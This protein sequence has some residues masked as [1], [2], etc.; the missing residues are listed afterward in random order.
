MLKIKMLQLGPVMT[1]AY[2]VAHPETQEA[3]VIDPA[4][5]G[6]RILAEASNSEW[7]IN[8]VWVTHAHFDHMGGTAALVDGLK[9]PPT[10]SLHPGD[11]P[12]WQAKG[13]ATYFGIPFESSADPGVEL[14]HGDSLALGNLTVEV[15]HAPGHTFFAP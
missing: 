13:G 12:L 14:A 4:W 1:N 3:V 10:V 5:D 11:L 7:N 9:P 15:R 6:D 2:L 8:Q